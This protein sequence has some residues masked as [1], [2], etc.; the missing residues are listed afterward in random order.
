[1]IKHSVSAPIGAEPPGLPSRQL[2]KQQELKLL[3]QHWADTT[4]SHNNG[5]PLRSSELYKSHMDK[6][7]ELYFA[8]VAEE[9]AAKAALKKLSVP[10]EKKLEPETVKKEVK[11][12]ATPSRDVKNA[13]I[14]VS[15]PSFD[16]WYQFPIS[17]HHA[18]ACVPKT[19]SCV[20]AKDGFHSESKVHHVETFSRV[21][22]QPVQP[23]AASVMHFTAR[24]LSRQAK[25]RLAQNLVA[26]DKV[27]VSSLTEDTTN[28]VSTLIA[29]PFF[30]EELIDPGDQ[31]VFQAKRLN[32]RNPKRG[33]FTVT[34]QKI[35]PQVNTLTRY[36]KDQSSQ[37]GLSPAIAKPDA[38][39]PR[40]GGTQSI[41]HLCDLQE[42]VHRT[43]HIEPG[44]IP[45]LLSFCRNAED[46]DVGMKPNIIRKPITRLVNRV[47]GRD[48][49][50]LIGFETDEQYRG[51]DS[52]RSTEGRYGQ[53]SK[54]QY[55]EDFEVCNYLH[56]SYLK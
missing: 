10:A 36:C 2:T 29:L 32:S 9:K 5:L 25:A 45:S 31:S 35:V 49:Q 38:W 27:C 54:S 11:Q 15:R 8:I 40:E 55:W 52:S 1:M 39:F 48:P 50:G 41:A 19:D 42:R 17:T 34:S 20:S 21:L 14:K 22:E 30:S 13:N 43:Y 44:E 51:T 28:S 46:S 53:H 7:A 47:P 16:P 24:P 33:P 56:R 4:P 18:K 37:T 26:P 12:V 6:C 23:D 3:E